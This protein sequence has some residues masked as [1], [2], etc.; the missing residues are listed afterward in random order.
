VHL[1]ARWYLYR[2]DIVDDNGLGFIVPFQV[3]KVKL[4]LEKSFC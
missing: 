1:S 2:I 4:F 3:P